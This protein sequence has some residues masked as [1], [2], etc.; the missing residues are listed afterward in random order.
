M[1]V[2]SNP[3]HER[4]AQELAQG[5]TADQ[6]YVLAGYKENRFNASRLKTNEHILRRVEEFVQA[7]AEKAGVTVDRIIAEL[8]T[9]G[10]SN[11]ADYMRVGPDG[12]PTLD[13]TELTRDQ[14]SALHEVTVET[15][16]VPGDK[17]GREVQKVKFKLYDKRAALVDLGK[18]LGMFSDKVEHS[19][20]L[21]IRQED[22]LA[23]LK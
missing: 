23:A 15:S 18:H 5:K 17:E 4:F 1:P 3:K 22:A 12:D 13:F 16:K 20:S 14:T 6:A 7:G 9:L 11:M 10:F 19:G 8:A 2:L 21:T